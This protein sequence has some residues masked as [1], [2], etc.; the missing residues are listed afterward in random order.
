MFIVFTNMNHGSRITK[1]SGSVVDAAG[2]VSLVLAIL[3][4]KVY[5]NKLK[6]SRH[7]LHFTLRKSSAPVHWTSSMAYLFGTVWPK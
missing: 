2:V 5:Q 1:Y 3:D 4:D 6:H 7:T